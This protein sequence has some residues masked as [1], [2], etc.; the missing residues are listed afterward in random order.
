MNQVCSSGLEGRV[1][2]NSPWG[3]CHQIT[4]DLGVSVRVCLDELM[5]KPID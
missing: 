4:P 3:A 1:V 5:F 2:V